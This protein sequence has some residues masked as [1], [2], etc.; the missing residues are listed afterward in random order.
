MNPIL[1]KASNQK[2]VILVTKETDLKEIIL[3]ILI[4]TESMVRLKV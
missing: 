2:G 1:L 3:M 4:S